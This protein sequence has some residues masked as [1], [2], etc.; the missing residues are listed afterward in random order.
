[1]RISAGVNRVYWD[2]RHQTRRAISRHKAAEAAAAVWRRRQRGPNVLPGDYRVT[3]V[4]DGKM[5]RPR[6]SASAATRT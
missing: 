4:V 1:M 5:S 3:L 6:P 2:L